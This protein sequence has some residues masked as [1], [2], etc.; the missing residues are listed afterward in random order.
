VR[1]Q[2]GLRAGCL[3]AAV[4]LAALCAASTLPA[5]AAPSA[6]TLYREALA[7]TDEWSVHYASGGTIAKVPILE[8]G[9]AGPA[10]GVQE[11]LVGR[12][13]T[14]DIAELI[15]IGDI[16]Y[17]KGNAR[18]LQDL[19]FLSPSQAAASAG[20]WILFSTDNPTFSQVVVGIRSRDVAKELVMKGPFTLGRKRRIDGIEVDAIRGTQD[21]PGLKPMRAVLYVRADGAHRVVEEDT[22]NAKGKPNGIEHTIYSD[23]GETVRPSAP[24]ASLSIGKV[25]GI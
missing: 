21:L 22:L 15:V 23:W 11:V 14:I 12:G 20:K 9:D 16:T 4:A 2:R 18:A 7:T 1:V 5:G 19:I 25:S 17:V 24:Q 13:T 6:R 10:S 8:S 3:T